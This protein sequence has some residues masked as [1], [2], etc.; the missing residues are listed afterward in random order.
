MLATSA[1][2]HLN[3]VLVNVKAEIFPRL[4]QADDLGAPQTLINTFLT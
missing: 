2:A 3:K 4:Q 1:E